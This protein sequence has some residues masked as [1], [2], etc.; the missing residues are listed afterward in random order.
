MEKN[1]IETCRFK[2]IVKI[3]EDLTPEEKATVDTKMNWLFSKL[4]VTTD[5]GFTYYCPVRDN[6]EFSSVSFFVIQL[7]HISNYFEELKFIQIPKERHP[8]YEKYRFKV[9]AKPKENLSLEDQKL[10]DDKMEFLLSRLNL[11]KIDNDYTY[12]CPVRN[13]EDFGNVTILYNNL[14]KI[15]QCFK[16]LEY[17]DYVDNDYEVAV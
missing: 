8:D 3:R 14:K 4:N 11:A 12:Y 9:V 10:L 15:K 2:A 5:D 16:N 13:N 17:Y 1:T 6:Q 7:E